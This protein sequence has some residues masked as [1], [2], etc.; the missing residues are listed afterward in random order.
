MGRQAWARIRTMSVAHRSDVRLSVERA[1]DG[2]AVL[3]DLAVA[4][5]R[6]L[7]GQLRRQVN[8]LL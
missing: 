8:E 6:D 4:L 7:T 2:M 3:A 1:P 5:P